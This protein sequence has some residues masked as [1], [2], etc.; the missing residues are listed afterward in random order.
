M[1]GSPWTITST[2]RRR[3]T[4]T[5]TATPTATPA[6]R[7]RTRTSND[8][9]SAGTSKR[10]ALGQQTLT[11]IDFVKSPSFEDEDDLDQAELEPIGQPAVQRHVRPGRQRL[12]KRDS[13]LTQMD[14]FDPL[15]AAATNTLDDHIARISQ[16]GSPGKRPPIPAFDGA[17]DHQLQPRKA[18]DHPR[19]LPENSARTTKATK[20]AEKVK[21]LE[22]QDGH[23]EY[24]PRKR[25]KVHIDED[26]RGQE[27]R[28][29]SGRIAAATA[30]GPATTAPPADTVSQAASN[31]GRTHFSSAGRPIL[32]VQDSTDFTEPSLDP[33][34]RLAVMMAQPV[35]P[36]KTRDRIPSSQTPESLA[37]TR[38]TR[39]SKRQPLADLNTN[40]QKTP[41]KVAK[42]G[43]P[44]IRS[45]AKHSPRRR[46]CVLKVPQKALMPRTNR[47]DDSQQ[48]IWSVQA[49]S[50]PRREKGS[51][52]LHVQRPQETVL[53]P[54][55]T[56]TSTQLSRSQSIGPS[57][58]DS[59]SPT[60][61]DTQKSL[62]D[63]P[64]ILGFAASPQPVAAKHDQ[65]ALM[66]V[67]T[68]PVAVQEESRTIPAGHHNGMP[69]DE[70]PV[71]MIPELQQ[72][73]SDE[74]SDFGSPVANDT[75]FV[76]SLHN[77]VSSPVSRSG[78]DKYR[79]KTAP[80]SK[81]PTSSIPRG[82]SRAS[83]PT[84]PPAF[85]CNTTPL[86][87]PRLVN[88]S[89]LRA[90]QQPA[91]AFSTESLPLLAT[92]SRP[93]KQAAGRVRITKVPLND[94]NEYQLSSSSSSPSLPPPPRPT[95]KSVHPASIPHPS[96]VSTQAPSTQGF[97]FP[98][99]SAPN[100]FPVPH[101]AEVE[102]ITIKD[103]SSVPTR[104]S[105]IHQH[106]QDDELDAKGQI[107]LLDEHDD[108][109]DDLDLDPSTWNT[110]TRNKYTGH[111][112]RATGQLGEEGDI[113]QTPTQ[114]LRT[115][116]S[117]TR[118]ET[119][120]LSSPI[121][122]NATTRSQRDAE[123]EV[124]ALLSSSQPTEEQHE[125]EHHTPRPTSKIQHTTTEIRDFAND[126]P[127]QQSPP[128]SLLSSSIFSPSPPRQLRRKYSPIPG[129]D[130]DT[131]S[132]FTQDGHVTA[133]YIHRMRE[134]G[135]LPK[136]YV[137]KPFKPKNWSKSMRSKRQ[138]ERAKAGKS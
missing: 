106:D 76:K 11:Q 29:R 107:R 108:D 121:I 84:S 96:Q 63:I 10:R 113:T 31:P 69:P 27:N 13:T 90:V 88:T 86:P 72:V 12:K 44:D 122:T 98:S 87:A 105:H 59:T 109:D 39:S 55:K 19:L 67:S 119:G 124:I 49:T 7:K 45:P 77:R 17:Q 117:L 30:S 112:N 89:P 104:L 28:R 61:I 21:N 47:V 135:L 132:D 9:S 64:A 3:T 97:Y 2:K 118:R 62:P 54:P 123:L 53:S 116:S 58:Q 134:E 130:N 34:S 4:A 20:Q 137:P 52:Q 35:T 15:T 46:I 18:M 85:A 91:A 80:A 71:N 79:A 14:F 38:R 115:R 83:V 60:E 68:A 125:E 74:L 36:S 24:Q 6:P 110:P 50:S 56:N 133:A 75:Q 43:K 51:S 33:T 78:A 41:S 126:Q 57:I 81:Q 40:I 114:I 26:S 5:A 131:Q 16:T 127:N 129:F 73:S 102:R 138:H 65:E 103:S 120:G 99:S 95:Q 37:R 100:S 25:R 82:L 66:R 23:Q 111:D 136:S 42:L 101:E 8:V 22:G 1:P 92:K 32:E 94:T 128:S 70:E 93:A 48:D